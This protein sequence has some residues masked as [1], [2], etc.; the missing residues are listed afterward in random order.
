MSGCVFCGIVA[1]E[2]PAFR[3]A[4]TPDGV[5][6]LDTRPVFKG[7]VLVVPRT[8]LV[9]LADLPSDL[10]P[11]YFALVQR[12]AV[13]VESGLGAGGTFVAMNNKVS[14]SVPHLHTHVVPRTKGDG[15]RGFFWPRTRYEDDTEAQT[16]AD[17]VAAALCGAA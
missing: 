17:R 6:F 12:L 8:H 10:L 3:V 16:Y 4:D 14:Q 11:G 5:A 15:L 2:V 1:G 13:A 9:T 7:H